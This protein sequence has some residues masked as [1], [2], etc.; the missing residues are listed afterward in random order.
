MNDNFPTLG[1]LVKFA[2]DAAGVLPRKR[3]END[4]LN[5]TD[6]KRI[7]KQLER[8]T[9]EEGSL[10]ERC[11]ELIRTLA[12]LT[13]GAIPNTKANLAFGEVVMDLFE[14]YN[15]AIRDEGT[16]LNKKDSIL[17]ICRVYA[18][19][20]LALSIPK[21]SLGFHLRSEGFSIPHDPN[22]Y[23]PTV[24]GDE[25]DWPLRKAMSWVYEVCG[26]SRTHFHYPGKSSDIDQPEQQQNLDNASAWFKGKR[27]PSWP[28][29]YWN[30]SRS[31]EHLQSHADPL[32]RRQ[33]S[34]NLRESIF[35][36]LFLARLSTYIC[37]L[38]RD[39]YGSVVLDRLIT[40]FKQHRDWLAVDL[41]SFAKET[42]SYIDGAGVAPMA[43][44][45][46]WMRFSERYWDW[47]SERFYNLV[48]ELNNLLEHHDHMLLPKNI[49]TELIERYG[50]YSVRTALEKLEI[51]HDFPI[52]PNF[53]LRLREGFE[54][55]A[56]IDCNDDDIDH[57]LLEIQQDGLV[58]HLNWMKHWLRAV[59]R[60]RKREYKSAFSHM[61]CAFEQAKYRAGHNQYQLVNQF[62]ELAAKTNRWKCFKKGIEWA[63]YLGISV[64][65]LR[66]R[67][68]DEEALQFVYM[69]MQKANYVH[70]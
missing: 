39:N 4:G 11:G 18:I 15:A 61:E 14:V 21:H 37:S 40:Q 68:P 34:D 10:T 20:R 26:I 16:Y 58:S 3:G 31:L 50:E 69:M 45:E 27:I 59:V 29:L 47:F 25:V 41:D 23:L 32:R 30:F 17:W 28:S 5:D 52:P 24:D 44:D 8:L 65:W 60:Y 54:L 49:V 22:W 7:Q 6:K 56:D 2:F 13:A 63:R 12:F 51:N 19:P 43:Q 64:R 62:I 66:D 42:T 33:F 67:E 70:F 48:S 57:Y 46:V 53:P 38:I 35:L 9:N 55:K 1:E 36:V